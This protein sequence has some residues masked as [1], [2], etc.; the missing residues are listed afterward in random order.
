VKPVLAMLVLAFALWSAGQMFLP[1]RLPNA[2][3]YAA[4]ACLL[5]IARK[6][7]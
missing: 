5:A 4:C 6:Q 1:R 3:T 2:L 7:L